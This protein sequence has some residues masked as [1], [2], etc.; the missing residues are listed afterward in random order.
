MQGDY[1]STPHRLMYKVKPPPYELTCVVPT[2][3][4]ESFLLCSKGY[5]WD[6]SI[7]QKGLVGETACCASIRT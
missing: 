5:E 2:N 4:Y 3:N 6:F 7:L 1:Q